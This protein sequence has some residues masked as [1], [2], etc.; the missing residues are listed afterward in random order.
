MA[1]SYTRMAVFRIFKRI[2]EAQKE[3]VLIRR[4]GKD[5]E[6]HFQ[7]WVGD[8]IQEAGYKGDVLGRN[9]YPDFVLSAV[10]E[11]YEVKG[12]EWPGRI[13]T[14][15]ANSQLP[16]G[17][18]NDREIF[19][20]FGRYPKQAEEENEE[21][22]QEYPLIDLII[23]HG[24][25]LNADNTYVHRNKHVLGFGSYGDI[26]IRDRKM[27]VVP[28]PF[29]LTEPTTTGLTTLILPES[30]PVEQVDPE[31]ASE[32]QV[33]GELTRQE[34][35]KILIAYSFDLRK[36]RICGRFVNNPNA[37]RKH[38]FLAYRLKGDSDK[39]VQMA[40]PKKEKLPPWVYEEQ[41]DEFCN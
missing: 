21:E 31:M 32:F 33:V 5:K 30:M 26:M 13:E 17:F 35:E 8:R 24:S 1:I 34:A 11:G 4:R 6:F 10:P 19:Y 22:V 38:R 41:V 28:T 25:F 40:P 9:R 15:D 12:L 37:G 23:C 3:G 29:Y 7:N 16:K 2:V 20:V 18:F 36:N 39:E 27:Y 14:F